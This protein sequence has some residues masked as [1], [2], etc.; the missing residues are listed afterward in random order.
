RFGGFSAMAQVAVFSSLT[1]MV[2]K[3]IGSSVAEKFGLKKTYVGAKILGLMSISTLIMFL[4][5]PGALPGAMS[6]VIAHQAAIP[7]GLGQWLMET[8]GFSGPKAGGYIIK[9]HGFIP[10]L[11]VYPVTFV[12]AIGLYIFG[13]QLPKKTNGAVDGAATTSPD[14]SLREGGSAEAT[15][16]PA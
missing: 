11:L 7:L 15:P 4:L 6:W 10:A 1:G 5:G 13:I 16:A 12:V 3:L 9:N 14:P 8:V 2:G